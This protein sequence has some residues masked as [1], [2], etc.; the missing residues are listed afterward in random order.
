MTVLFD[1]HT[2]ARR[3]HGLLEESMSGTGITPVEFAVYSTL[4]ARD[5]QTPS[6][7]ASSSSMPPSSLTV[8]LGR[9]EERGHLLREVN[10]A[11]ARSRLVSLSE[12]GRAAHKAAGIAF[13]EVMEP[14]EQSL[15]ADLRLVRW[16]LIRLEHVLREMTDEPAA[17]VS[18]L[19][20]GD[21]ANAVDYVGRR[22]TDSEA[23]EVRRFIGYI[24]SGR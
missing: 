22:L 9:M 23:T 15:G 5:R 6:E 3:M 21:D 19:D 24:Q 14:L 4:V 17:G 2:V 12:S 20:D 16:S 1:V 8:L 10:P 13:R 18:S 11:D 7:L